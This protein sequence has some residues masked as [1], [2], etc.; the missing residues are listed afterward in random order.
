MSQDQP[1]IVTAFVAW[2]DIKGGALQDIVRMS[3][4]P[5]RRRMVTFINGRE[6]RFDSNPNLPWGLL[7]GNIVVL[8]TLL[9]QA[10]NKAVQIAYDHFPDFTH[11]LF[12]DADMMGYDD[13]LVRRLLSHD[14]PIVAPMMTRRVHPFSPACCPVEKGGADPLDQGKD[15]VTLEDLL[16]IMD[17]PEHTG[18]AECWHV[19]T[20]FMLIRRDALEAVKED[21]PDGS[22]WFHV[23]RFPRMGIKDE[24]NKLVKEGM[25]KEYPDDAKLDRIVAVNMLRAFELGLK[26]RERSVLMG[27]DVIFCRAARAKGFPSFVDT[28]V[29]IKHLG[30]RP[31]DIK[32]ALAV[33][34]AEQ[35][36]MK[37]LGPWI[38]QVSFNPNVP[39]VAA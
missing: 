34:R 5:F 39:Q 17:E 2:D 22:T 33:M 14:V 16:R 9:P 4:S 12:V 30:E 35:E 38:G 24:F 21:T 3:S 6:M 37:D 11:F 10:R 25:E 32:D 13:D 15:E 18:L 23:D 36:R 29:S 27:E 26:S 1:R 8:G 28:H 31:Y 20:A 19:G 7:T